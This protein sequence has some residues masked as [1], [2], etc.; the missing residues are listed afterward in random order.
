MAVRA[1]LAIID[2]NSGTERSDAQIK[3]WKAT[4]Q[5]RSLLT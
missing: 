1:E 5:T 3:K 4:L 2:H